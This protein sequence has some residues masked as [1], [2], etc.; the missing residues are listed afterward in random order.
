MH[1][2]NY[3]GPRI[4]DIEYYFRQVGRNNN[5]AKYIN[6]I[7]N[8]DADLETLEKELEN[9][10]AINLKVNF[11][12]NNRMT[13]LKS[14]Q[15]LNDDTGYKDIR[16]K[17][18]FNRTKL[19][20]GSFDRNIRGTNLARDIISWI[21]NDSKNIDYLDDLKM[22]YLTEGKNEPEFLDFLKNKVTSSITIPL[23]DGKSYSYKELRELMA[24]E[25]YY[26]LENGTTNTFDKE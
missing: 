12:Y 7:L 19:Q 11:G 15:N 1:E 2:F 20:N 21:R 17:M 6:Y 9:V 24:N 16:L 4:S 3:E 10:F 22:D 23:I 8:Y 25:F 14:L 26:Y 5:I 18:H 13:W